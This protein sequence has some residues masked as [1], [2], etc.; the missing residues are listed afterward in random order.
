M[1]AEII[2]QPTLPSAFNSPNYF[3][4][5]LGYDFHNIVASVGYFYDLCN[6]D[7]PE[8]NGALFGYSLRY[9]VKLDGDDCMSAGLYAEVLRINKTMEATVGFK[10]VF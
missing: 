10:V 2:E 7:N 5:K 3:G 6:S 4:G 1:V 9:Y 8:N